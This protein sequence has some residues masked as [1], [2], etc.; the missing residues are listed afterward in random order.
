MLIAQIFRK[1][2]SQLGESYYEIAGAWEDASIKRVQRTQVDT[3]RFSD[4]ER[5]LAQVLPEEPEL[6]VEPG[7]ELPE[8]IVP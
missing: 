6:S 7:S 8:A 4:C 3:A 1:P 2:L 5:Y